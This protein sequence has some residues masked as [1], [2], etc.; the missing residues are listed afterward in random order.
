M[1]KFAAKVTGNL[2]KTPNT[3][4]QKPPEKLLVRGVQETPKT[5]EVIAVALG[6]L[7]ETEDELLLLKTK[8]IQAGSN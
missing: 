1:T 5:L 4:S 6:C 7:L 8:K 3:R 2:A